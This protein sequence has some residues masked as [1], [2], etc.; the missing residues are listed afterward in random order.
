MQGTSWY[1]SRYPLNYSITIRLSSRSPRS[2]R[3]PSQEGTEIYIRVKLP[4]IR[5]YFFIWRSRVTTTFSR[6]RHGDDQ[7]D[8]PRVDVRRSTPGS[9]DPPGTPGRSRQRGRVLVNYGQRRVEGEPFSLGT[10]R[11]EHSAST[12]GDCVKACNVTY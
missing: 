9:D 4:C 3:D 10:S 5:L 11:Q 2:D 8:E 12:A 6:R 1:S 7:N